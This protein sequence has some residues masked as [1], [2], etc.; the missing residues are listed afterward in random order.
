MTWI[1]LKLF[2]NVQSHPASEI[3]QSDGTSDM[4]YDITNKILSY[5]DDTSLYAHILS[6]IMSR[7]VADSLMDM[8][9]LDKIQSW[10]QQWSMMLNPIKSKDNIVR[11]SRT[12][13]NFSC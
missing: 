1:I 4:W 11:R 3:T 7:G 10:C 6:P 13:L 9:D 2:I 12:L 5:A 8:D